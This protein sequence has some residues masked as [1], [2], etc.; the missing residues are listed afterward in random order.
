M[1]ATASA[2]EPAP[3][4]SRRRASKPFF[5]ND[6]IRPETSVLWMLRRAQVAI[7]QLVS[8][9]TELGGATVPQWVPLYKIHRGEADTVADLARRCTVDAGYMTRLLD[10]LEARGLCRR[11]RSETDRR[12]VHIALTPEGVAAAEQMPRVLARV[13]NEVLEDFTPEE[14]AQLRM[15]LD[16]VAGKAESLLGRAAAQETRP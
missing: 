6:G 12:V 2:P 5:D 3:R 14:W 13:Y 16:R 10:R 11:V 9:A 7:G 1:P 15:L 4:A 8:E